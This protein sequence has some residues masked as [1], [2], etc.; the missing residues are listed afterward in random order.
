VPPPVANDDYDDNWE[1]DRDAPQGRDLADD[2]EDETPTVPCPSC[3]RE[4]A[5]FADRCPHCGDWVVQGG[6]SRPARRW[7]L[8]VVIVII[9]AFLLWIVL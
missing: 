1:D 5:E 4:V 9:V 2:D 7:P 6:D 8:I 3:G